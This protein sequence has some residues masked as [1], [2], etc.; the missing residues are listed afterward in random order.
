[1]KTNVIGILRALALL[2]ARRFGPPTNFRA[3]LAATAGAVAVGTYLYLKLRRRPTP[4]PPDYG[5]AAAWFAR[6]ADGAK[7]ADCF[8]AHATTGLGLFEWNLAVTDGTVCTGLV[9][10]DPDLMVGS[11][12]AWADSCNIWAPKYR[13][14]GMLSQGQ[15]LSTTD[16]S[17]LAAVKASLDLAVG[18][19]RAA[20]R[21]FLEARPDKARPFVIA[22]HS[23]GSILMTKVIADCIEGTQHE[24]Q[25]VAAY[26]C[27]GYVPMDLFGSVYRS[28]HPCAGPEDARCIISFDTRTAAF[29]PESINNL[30]LGLGLWPHHLY[31]LLHDRYCE[32]PHGTDD[33]SK[34]RLQTN[35]A[36]WS[37]DGGGE[38]LGARLPGSKGPQLPPKGYGAKTRVTDKAVVV[39]DPQQWLPGA[40]SKGGPG[41]MHPID[42]HFWFENIRANV[43]ARIAAVPR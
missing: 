7:P 27:G 25:F 11:A 22:G 9:A 8:Y 34:P 35:P 38:H 43:A 20:F 37:G 12:G 28:I 42:C 6:Q 41:N 16:E 18:D 40:G 24:Q 32:R 2:I 10:G 3:A 39:E 21:A 4:P 13:Q 33:I 5:T 26:L 31:W 14:M 29:K 19:L 23:Q 15:M 17:K 36:V 1:M 30:G